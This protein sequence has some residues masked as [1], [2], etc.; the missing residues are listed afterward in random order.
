M[1]TVCILSSHI[2][3]FFNMIFKIFDT[4]FLQLNILGVGL[5]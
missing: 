1:I 2:F 3:F 5:F 4:L